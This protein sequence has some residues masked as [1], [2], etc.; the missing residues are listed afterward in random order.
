MKSL[1]S[2]A[3]REK[4]DALRAR[5]AAAW[6]KKLAEAEPK[7]CD[8]CDEPPTHRVRWTVYGGRTVQKY[9]CERHSATAKGRRGVQVE[10]VSPLSRMA[11]PELVSPVL[12]V[13][14]GDQTILEAGN[15]RV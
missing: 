4:L 12:V 9:V 10:R 7:S 5:S 6:E 11:A 8:Y 2:D 3:G 13:A 1:F 15:G 14:N